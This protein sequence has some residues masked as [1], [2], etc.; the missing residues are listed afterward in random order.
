MAHGEVTESPMGKGAVE[1]SREWQSIR[2]CLLQEGSLLWQAS[3][4][5]A[6][7][8]CGALPSACDEVRSIIKRILPHVQHFAYMD[9]HSLV[10][11]R[12]RH[13]SSV[14]FPLGEHAIYIGQGD[15]SVP[16]FPS[17]ICNPYSA[18]LDDAN[19]C[20]AFS[21]FFNARPDRLFVFHFVSSKSLVCDCTSSTCHGQVIVDS[22]EKYLQEHPSLR[23]QDNETACEEEDAPQDDQQYFVADPEHPPRWPQAWRNLVK[24]A[25]ANPTRVFWEFFAGVAILTEHFRMLGWAVLPPIDSQTNTHYNLLNP[26]FL[27]IVIGLILE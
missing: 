13:V 5:V 20:L 25:R 21:D 2:S 10:A 17:F 1:L 8:L 3:P 6:T 27:C 11:P 9:N 26:I 23:P 24:A 4:F 7:F 22:M 15:R 14:I 16:V 19:A 18:F 12:L